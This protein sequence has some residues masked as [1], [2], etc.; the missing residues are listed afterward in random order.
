VGEWFRRHVEDF[1]I[2]GI[3][4]VEDVATLNP[5][6]GWAIGWSVAWNNTA[7]TLEMNEPPG[8][9]NWS[10]G[11]RGEAIDPKMPV[12]DGSMRDPLNRLRASRWELQRGHRTCISSS[13]GTSGTSG[14]EEYRL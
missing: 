2:Q 3:G 11:N 5:A 14:G 7:K 10:I 1:I 12:F 4:L 13:L 6:H 8:I 9:L